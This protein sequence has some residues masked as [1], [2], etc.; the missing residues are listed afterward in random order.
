MYIFTR[1]RALCGTPTWPMATRHSSIAFQASL[2]PGVPALQ[3]F[4]CTYDLL[5]CDLKVTK[6]FSTAN[7]CT[8]CKG[9]QWVME[10]RACMLCSCNDSPPVP[11]AACRRLRQHRGPQSVPCH[12]PRRQRPSSQSRRS[13]APAVT[14]SA[15]SCSA[16][17]PLTSCTA[18]EMADLDF[19]NDAA[20]CFKSTC[21]MPVQS[22]G[23]RARAG[24]Q[25]RGRRWLPARRDSSRETAT[26]R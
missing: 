21:G 19:C 15:R 18:A 11:L 3:S 20:A 2:L 7:C 22:G 26:A 5:T 8:L 23:L 6:C 12:A 9:Q 4:P 10:P 14:M 1:T 24:H 17:E 25:S 13:T 16:T